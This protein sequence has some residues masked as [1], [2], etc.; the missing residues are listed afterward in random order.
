MTPSV[1]S[2]TPRS[3]S[4]AAG[5][6][7]PTLVAALSIAA[8]Q[9]IAASPVA[10]QEPGDPIP[11]SQHATV[12]QKL[13]SVEVHVEYRR[14]VARGRDVFG[15]LVPWERTWTP[16]A[17]SAA[18]L[19]LSGELLVAGHAVPAGSYS[20]WVVPRTPGRDWTLI[21]S[22][23][24]R[25]FH[26]PYPEGQDQLRVDLPATTGEHMET[27]ALYFPVADRGRGV[28]TLHWAETVLPIPLELPPEA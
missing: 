4:G 9:V 3:R 21:L 6:A 16:S 19:T 14:P 5:T 26:A 1:P 23:A 28:L 25:V 17:D 11:L 18:V 15:A 13:G 8:A 10:G 24:A 22:R 12:S 7:R 20:L 2:P 27:L